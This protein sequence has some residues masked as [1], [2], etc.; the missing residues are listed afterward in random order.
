MASSKGSGTTA[1]GALTL[2]C[3]RNF[4]IPRQFIYLCTGALDPQQGV[5]GSQALLSIFI[6]IKLSAYCPKGLQI[7]FLIV[8]FAFWLAKFLWTTV[9]YRIVLGI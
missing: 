8:I 2:W 6:W 7:R 3:P 9:N 1:C 4:S 5:K